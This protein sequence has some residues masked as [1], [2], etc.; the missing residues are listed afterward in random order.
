MCRKGDIFQMDEAAL[1]AVE[2]VKGE[3]VKQHE[4]SSLSAATEL[5]IDGSS[6]IYGPI[7]MQNQVNRK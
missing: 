5:L 2:Q 4:V 7:L 6:R 1:E 3:L